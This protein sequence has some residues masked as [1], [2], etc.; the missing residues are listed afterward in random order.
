MLRLINKS[1]FHQINKRCCQWSKF[2]SSKNPE[3]EGTNIELPVEDPG[4]KIKRVMKRDFAFMKKKVMF[5]K[6]FKNP[7]ID[8]NTGRVIDWDDPNAPIF[9][10]YCDIVI[11]GGGAMGSSIAYWIKKLALRSLNVVVIEKDPTYKQCSTVLSVGGLRQQFS[12]EEN[13]EMS[14]FGAEFLRNINDYLGVEGEP[15]IDVQFQ[16]YGYLSLAS[17]PESAEVLMKN[18]EL[19]NEIGAKNTIL[20]AGQLSNKFPWLNTKDIEMGCLGLEKEGW[21]DP[22]TLLNAFKRKAVSL[23]VDYVKGE[24]VG[25]NFKK[26]SGVM[27]SGVAPGQFE[28]LNY[29]VVRTDDGKLRPIQ[30]SRCII[31]A[32]AGSGDIAKMAKIGLGKDMLSIP[33]PV[34]PRKRFVYCFHA[35][36]GPGLNTPMVIDPSGTYFRREGLANTYICGRSPDACDEPSC[37]N[38]DVDPTYF[39]EKI[40][41]TLAHRVKGFENLKVKSSWAGFYEYNKFD[42]NGIIGFHPY[43]DNI[44]FATGFS[45]HGIQKAPAVGRA[46]SELIQ[47]NTYTTINLNRLG[48][49]RFIT[50]E[51]MEENNVW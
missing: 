25:F 23:G 48:F 43:H 14:L 44:I 19:Q 20:T 1:S 31:A 38:L 16:P 49:D 47:Y 4:H 24:A 3:N 40:W 33:L 2:S 37:D 41:P 35:P 46:I 13:I 29:L 45:G 15:P 39:E 7:A 22:W 18:S 26:D 9:P 5:W 27:V 12:L 10:N 36:E 34:E 17:T 21:F 8:E 11:I 51:K 32:G 30:F 28:S 42:E 6:D 50:N